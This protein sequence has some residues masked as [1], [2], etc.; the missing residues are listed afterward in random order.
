MVDTYTDP[1]SGEIYVERAPM[2]H[3][4]IITEYIDFCTGELVNYTTPPFETQLGAMRKF[5]DIIKP[6]TDYL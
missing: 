4:N 6:W 2:P 3:P 1:K 5:L